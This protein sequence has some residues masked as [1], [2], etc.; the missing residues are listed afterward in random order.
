M[1]TERR[2][3]TENEITLALALYMQMPYGRISTSYEP[4]RRLAA[5][6]GRKPGAVSFKLANLAALDSRVAASGRKG[7]ENGSKLDQVV[8][9]RYVDPHFRNSLDALLTDASVIAGDHRDDLGDILPLIDEGKPVTVIQR[10][11]Q[12]YFR[13]IIL[14]QYDA[15]CLITGLREESL[16]EVAHI[17][18][19]AED[20][21]LRLV[22]SNGIT[23][24]PLMHRAYDANLL[25]IDGDGIIHVSDRLFKNSQGEL[26]TLL[27]SVHGTS[28]RYT[29]D[30]RPDSEYL[31]R[32]FQHFQK[33]DFKEEIWFSDAES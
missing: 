20:K 14:R 33:K 3:W 7:F 5:V 11:K 6:L 19:W 25:G 10:Q 12:R 1:T 18:P 21:T 28:L 31:D 17:V 15:S 26:H 4:V 27:E 16:L 2:N 23:L 30:A 29:T 13:G 32:H 22:P 9:N 8:W 24:N